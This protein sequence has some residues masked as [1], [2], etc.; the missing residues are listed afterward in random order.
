MFDNIRGKDSKET[1]IKER[2]LPS[3]IE[4]LLTIVGEDLSYLEQEVHSVQQILSALKKERGISLYNARTLTLTTL[5]VMK[6]NTLASSVNVITSDVSGLITTIN[7]P[8][9]EE[10]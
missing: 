2:E 6:C 1:E 8:K 7:P 3:N 4:S 9:K 5:I 10:G